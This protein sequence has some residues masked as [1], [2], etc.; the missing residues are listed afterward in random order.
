MAGGTRWLSVVVVVV[1]VVERA[2][3]YGKRANQAQAGL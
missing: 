2:A 3:Q 1:L